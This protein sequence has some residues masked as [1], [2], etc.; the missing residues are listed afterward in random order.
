M[1]GLEIEM[2]RYMRAIGFSNCRKRAELNKIYEAA[3]SQ[4]DAYH[5]FAD[6]EQDAVFEMSKA[7]GDG[8]GL[9]WTGILD[10]KDALC[11]HCFPYVESTEFMVKDS[12]NVEER[13]DG[14]VYTGAL[15]DLRSGVYI[16]FFLQNGIDYRE[17]TSQE[18]HFLSETVLVA[19]SGL[20]LQGTI[21]LPM[22]A[23]EQ[24]VQRKERE[25]KKRIKLLAAAKQGDEK[26][27]ESLAYQDMTMYTKVSKRIRTEDVF[28]IV[29][30]CFMPYGIECDLYS[31]VADILEAHEVTNGYTGEK[32]WKLKLCYNGIKMDIC[33]NDMDLMGEPKAG[34]RFKGNIWLQGNLKMPKVSVD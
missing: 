29:E 8:I 33:I 17:L 9:I 16:I 15:E 5:V 22:A 3:C 31:V 34:R 2:N 26:A 30:S 6:G 24:E 32:I 11:E 13:V 20:S 4:P 10:G 21:L 18:D 25:Q 23:T 27:M 19:L 28:S 7:Y 1:E 14:N 12:V